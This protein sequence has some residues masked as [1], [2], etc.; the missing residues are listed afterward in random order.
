MRISQ[1]FRTPKIRF[2]LLP[3]S[4]ANFFLTQNF[5]TP[6]FFVLRKFQ[7]RKFWSDKNLDFLSYAFEIVLRKWPFLGYT[8]EIFL[9]ISPK[10]SNFLSKILFFRQNPKLRGAFSVTGRP[11]EEA[12]RAIDFKGPTRQGGP[13]G[14]PLVATI[15]PDN[16]K[17]LRIFVPNIRTDY[18]IVL[19]FCDRSKITKS[20]SII[21]ETPPPLRVRA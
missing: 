12:Y 19:D 8:L 16:S 20:P 4:P 5:R 14:L 18:F 2:L 21:T 15:L 3:L 11:R 7:N 10:I 6:K 13:G 17:N 9:Q 1:N